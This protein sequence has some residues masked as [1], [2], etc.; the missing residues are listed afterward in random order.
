MLFRS[1]QKERRL[2]FAA[3]CD[4][5][6]RTGPADSAN[7]AEAETV[8][9]DENNEDDLREDPIGRITINV[10]SSALVDVCFYLIFVQL[11]QRRLAEYSHW[12]LQVHFHVE[13][14]LWFGWL[15]PSRGYIANAAAEFIGHVYFSMFL[16][17]IFESSCLV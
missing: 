3:L 5:W 4:E 11:I 12:L 10:D 7:D 6:S 16:V 1:L 14:P 2:R 9:Y 13:E 8:L 15:R 17:F